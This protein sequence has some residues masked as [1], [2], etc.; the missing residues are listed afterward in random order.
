MR[1]YYFGIMFIIIGLFCLAGVK[2]AQAFTGYELG[3]TDSKEYR[4]VVFLGGS[5]SVFTGTVKETTKTKGDIVQTSLTYKMEDPTS[6]GKL[7]RTARLESKITRSGTQEVYETTLTGLTETIK[8]SDASLKLNKDDLFFSA[9]KIVDHRSVIDFYTEN[10]HFKKVYEAG[11]SGT[12]GLLVY[13]AWGTREGYDSAWG[14]GSTANVTAQVTSLPNATGSADWEGTIEAA[15]VDSVSRGLTYAQSKTS[16]KSFGG[17]YT[18]QSVTEE[19]L[20]INYDF[21]SSISPKVVQDFRNRGT[22]PISMKSPPTKKM[23]FAKDFRDVRGHWAQKD[24]EIVCGLG[25][26]NC[27]GN[28]FGPGNAATRRDIA[29]ALSAVCNLVKTDQTKTTSS[30][31]AVVE[32]PYFV[33]IGPSDPDFKAIQENYRRGIMQGTSES[34]FRPNKTVTRAEAATVLINALGLSRL[35]PQPEYKTVFYDDQEIPF[36]AKDS[37]YVVAELGLMEGDGGF[38]RP[39]DKM[40]RAELACLLNNFRTYLNEGFKKDYA[41]HG[42]AFSPSAN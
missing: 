39:N 25:A 31:K 10:W 41:E 40:S 37:V 27:K 9:S 34:L 5:P 18:D 12:G 4:E 15:M 6:K 1:R 17:T 42:Y 11:K 14:K 32:E 2:P 38:F 7:S 29:Q 30:K 33:D 19:A 35:A 20:R 24:I 13:E 36:W 22:L 3:V 21:P 8:V 28:L 23:L 16:L 26:F